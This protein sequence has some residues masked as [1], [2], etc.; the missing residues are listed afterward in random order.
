MI[1]QYFERFPGIKTYIDETVQSAK[2][3][4]Y[5]STLMGRRRYIP[6]INSRNW[7]VRGFAERTAINM[8]IQGTAADIIK[9]AMID[10]QKMLDDEGHKSK[11]L[12][13]VHD[14]LIFEIAEEELDQLPEKIKDLMESAYELKVPLDVEMGVA[15][16]WL[17]AH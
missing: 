10:I 6:D 8:P 12:L 16:N 1:E 4:G 2:E 3:N 17:E 7:N 11:M 14:E 13:Q 5:V 15:D 9:L